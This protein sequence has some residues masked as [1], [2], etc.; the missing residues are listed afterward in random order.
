MRASGLASAAS[1]RWVEPLPSLT[2]LVELGPLSRVLLINT[3]CATDPDGYEW[4]RL[5]GKTA[6]EVLADRLHS[7]LGDPHKRGY[8]DLRVCVG[9]HN[10]KKL[11]SNVRRRP[12]G[13]YRPPP[14]DSP[15]STIQRSSRCGET[16]ALGG[17]WR[18]FCTQ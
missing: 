2:W 16:V 1:R 13:S 10:G 18:A 12:C 9:N 5:I 15:L 3:E 7:Q 17:E 8:A 11:I 4:L 6:A 14:L